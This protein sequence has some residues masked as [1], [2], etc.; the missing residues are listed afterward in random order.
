M[1]VSTEAENGS[2]MLLQ[3]NKTIQN[4]LF[5]YLAWHMLTFY[6]LF[7][8]IIWYKSICCDGFGFLVS[9]F[10]ALCWKRILHFLSLSLFL[11]YLLL[12]CVPNVQFPSCVPVFPVSPLFLYFMIYLDLLP[13]SSSYSGLLLLMFSLSVT[14]TSFALDY[15]IISWLWY[16]TLNHC[17]VE[18]DKWRP[19]YNQNN[20]RW[21]GGSG[22]KLHSDIFCLNPLLQLWSRHSYM[23]PK[24]LGYLEM[25]KLVFSR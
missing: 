11:P 12:S 6:K 15:R 17:N 25:S 13:V 8:L 2:Y 3:W 18:A 22:K 10:T 1:I 16:S 21:H 20:S 4:V 5:P 14:P 24:R 23:Y 9:W 7:S 19:G